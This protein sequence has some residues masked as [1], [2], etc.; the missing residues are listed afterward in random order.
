MKI[1]IPK[2]ESPIDLVE[3][4]IP[5]QFPRQVPIYLK[6][7][8]EDEEVYVETRDYQIDGTPMRE[9]YGLVSVF[10]LPDNIDA[11]QLAETVR[12]DLMDIFDA[13]AENFEINWN[14]HNWIGHIDENLHFSL[15]EKIHDVMSSITYDDWGLWSFDEWYANDMPNID[16][17]LKEMDSIDDPRIEELADELI[18]DA[19][20]NYY[21]IFDEPHYQ[22]VQYLKDRYEELLYND[23]E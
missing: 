22:I 19:K 7:D 12:D 8:W 13:A 14:G 5:G 3:V 23:D 4:N 18:D 11:T 10:R 9:F 6:I 15:S 17:R 16:K 1:N 21:V 2:F 20:N